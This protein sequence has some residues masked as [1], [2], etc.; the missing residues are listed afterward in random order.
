MYYAFMEEEKRH[1]RKQ[2]RNHQREK[3]MNKSQWRKL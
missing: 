1:G 3:N 2:R